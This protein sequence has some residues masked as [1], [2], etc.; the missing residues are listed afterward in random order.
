MREL[1]LG[2]DIGTSGARCVAMDNGGAVVAQGASALSDHG[3]NARDPAV[4]WSAVSQ[5]LK[6]CLSLID[7]N[8]VRA[9]AVDG[10]SGTIL[11]VNADGAALAQPMMYNDPVTDAGLLE[12]IAPLIPPESAA[13]GPTSGLA[14]MLTFQSVPHVARMLHQADWIAGQFSGRFDVTDE[15]NALK[16][17]YDPV[18]GNWPDW[19]A[20]SGLRVALLPS[21]VPPGTVTGHIRSDMAA[22]FGLPA[23]VAIVAGTT[24]GCASFLATGA[25]KVGDGVTALGS[26]LTIKLLSD[27]PIFAPEYGIYSHRILGMWLGGGA[28][29][30]GGKVLAHYFDSAALAALSTRLDADRPTGLDYYPLLSPGERFPVSNP[31]LPPRLTPR[32]PDDA[33]FLQAMLEGIARIEKAGYDR[34]A[35]LGAPALRRLRTVGGG[36]AND[37]WTAIRSAWLRVPFVPV[38]SGEAA[39]GAARLALH[40]VANGRAA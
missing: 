27:R 39:A 25:D 30:T 1:V 5:S 7:G 19:I 34:L 8:A 11:P 22:R 12:R 23:D 3:D 10:T 26:T 16:S 38:A 37:A 2:I 40:A 21:I 24:D 6:Q 17:G 32:P 28:S 36:A 29:N 33:T 4:W 15:N 18:A 13:H 31:S 9:I 35:E 14:K 20:R